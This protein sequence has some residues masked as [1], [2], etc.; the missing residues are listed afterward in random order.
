MK[1]T[2][3]YKEHVGLGAKVIPFGGYEMP[4]SY[5]SGIKSECMAVRNDVGI[6]DVSHMGQ[7][8]IEGKNVFEFLQNVLT[9][10]IA[11]LNEYDAQYTAICNHNGGIIDDLILYKEKN[12]YLL[13]VNA[14]NIDK[15]YNWL[16]NN[17]SNEIII[18]N[19]S[20]EYS[21]IA[22][23]GPNSRSLIED[24]TNQKQEQKF[25]TYKNSLYDNNKIIISRTG[26]TGELGYEIIGSH[27]IISELWKV[28]IEKGATPC[29]LASRDVLR[30]E[31]KYCLYGSDLNNNTTPIE[32]GLGWITSFKKGDFIG[33][34]A[35]L[36]KDTPERKN[37]ICFEMIERG[38]SR[39]G[40]DIIIDESK[41]GN[42]TSGTHSPI[43]NKSIGIGYIPLDLSNIGR[44]IYIDI[45]NKLVKAKIVK[46]PFIDNTSLLY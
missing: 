11:K 15:D 18:T 6:F 3:L 24:I 37:L 36:K 20:D 19:L 25:Y 38:I 21:L 34:E 10:D 23:Q 30:M 9:N 1:K 7:I 13:I 31:M 16:K 29:G 27:K 32:S 46:A 39:H 42:V 44:I 22:I 33:R 40:Y 8:R 43:L 41:V 45:R 26:Y 12:S 17:K 28:A 4:V 14:S 5:S 2:I 35:I